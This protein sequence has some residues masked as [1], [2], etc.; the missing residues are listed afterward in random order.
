ML[1]T[2]LIIIPN[3]TQLH[4]T[5]ISSRPICHFLT[6]TGDNNVFGNAVEP[7]FN[8]IME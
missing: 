8:V 6:Y 7:H 2:L 5:D 3:N 4:A 1:N